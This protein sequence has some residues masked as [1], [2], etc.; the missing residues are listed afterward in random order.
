MNEE[1]LFGQ[2]QFARNGTLSLLKDVSE[3][4][5]DVVPAGFKNNIRWHLGHIYVVQENLAIA[6]AGL[7]RE[8]PEGFKAA[9]AG[10]TSPADWTDRPATLEQLKQRLAEQTTRITSGLAGRLAQPLKT[11]FQI[12]GGPEWTT[13]GE[14][15]NFSLYHE[16]QHAGIIKGLQ[17]A[18]KA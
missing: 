10:G 14:M 3:E 13:V 7:Q 15:A 1:S 17:Y 12:P 9:F 5:A 4:M 6:S 11:P 18:I 2:L 8:V 16:G